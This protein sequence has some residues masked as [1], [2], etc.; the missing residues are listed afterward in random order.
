MLERHE[1]ETFLA[2]ADELHFGRAAD[3]LL[4]S[5]ARVSQTV[6]KLERRI[7]APLFERT[8]RRV[9]L[10]PL[11]RRLRDDVAEPYRA[12]LDG[13][14]RATAAARGV[15]GVLRLGVLGAYGNEILDVLDLF[16][17]RH[18]DCEVQIREIHFADPFEPL[19]TGDVDVAVMWLPVREPDLTVG[20]TVGTDAVVVAVSARH[21]FAGRESVSMEE[22]ADEVTVQPGVGSAPSYWI[23]AHAPRVTPSG[24]PIPAGP[25]AATVHELFSIVSA[26]LAISYAG[27]HGARYYAHPGLVFVPLA[28]DPRTEWALVWHTSGENERI[29]AFARAA[30]DALAQRPPA[31]D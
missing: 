2:V 13:F 23:E 11:G 14:A 21:R 10:T 6:S 29:K 5:R 3:R 9:S 16:R 17:A 20:P 24:R 30:E 7:G 27:R 28:E 22:L 15:A 1:I 12:V 19:R 26:G 18:P 31:E 25:D 4:V 8:S